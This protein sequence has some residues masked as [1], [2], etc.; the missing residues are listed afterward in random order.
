[1]S[2]YKYGP[3]TDYSIKMN[4]S[5]TAGRGWTWGVAG[6]TPIAGLN[7]SGDF[8]VAGSFLVG[9]PNETS[10]WNSLWQSGFYDGYNI[11]NAPESNQWFWGINM[12]HRSNSSNYRYGGQIAIKNSSSS[13]TMYFRSTNEQGEGTWAKV[14]NSVGSQKISSTN[15][16]LTIEGTG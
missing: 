1:T 15:T 14:L 12:N 10:D 6:A 7:T 5:N 9:K 8:Q 4:M 11:S 16:S 13:P 3:V 2:E